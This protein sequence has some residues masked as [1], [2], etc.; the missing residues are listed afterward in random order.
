MYTMTTTVSESDHFR[1]LFL[2]CTHP[3]KMETGRGKMQICAGGSGLQ[4]NIEQCVQKA[5]LSSDLDRRRRGAVAVLCKPRRA[6]AKKMKRKCMRTHCDAGDI[7]LPPFS[8]KNI[9]TKNTFL[10]IRKHVHT[11]IRKSSY[12]FK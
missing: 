6:P 11:H 12:R 9:G 7:F 4:R 8:K 10:F 3:A 5:P 2:F 1:N